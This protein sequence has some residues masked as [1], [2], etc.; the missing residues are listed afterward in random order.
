LFASPFAGVSA[1]TTNP[2]PGLPNPVVIFMVLDN[3]S[4]SG[5]GSA[6][7]GGLEMIAAGATLKDVLENL[8]NCLDS[9][10]SSSFSSILPIEAHGEQLQFGA[11]APEYAVLSYSCRSPLTGLYLVVSGI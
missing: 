7:Q 6:E 3:R 8:Y 11:C 1:S 9:Q 4:T 5:P 2:A 10:L